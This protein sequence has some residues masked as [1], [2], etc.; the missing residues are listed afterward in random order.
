MSGCCEVLVT[1]HIRRRL[2]RSAPIAWRISPASWWVEVVVLV[3]SAYGM[4]SGAEGIIGLVVE[5]VGGLDVS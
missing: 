4:L 3:Q 1:L 2:Q 5:A